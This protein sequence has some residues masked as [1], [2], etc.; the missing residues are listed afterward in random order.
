MWNLRRKNNNKYNIPL[1]QDFVS[2][3]DLF[4]FFQK[5]TI[6]KFI[7]IVLNILKIFKIEAFLKKTCFFSR[8]ILLNKY[9]YKLVKKKKKEM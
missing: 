9:Y 3:I 5:L 7:K 4:N 2:L 6:Y 1:S 8:K